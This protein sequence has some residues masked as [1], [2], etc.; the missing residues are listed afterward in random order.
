LSEYLSVSKAVLSV[1]LQLSRRACIAI[2]GIK[3]F[4][5]NPLDVEMRKRLNATCGVLIL[6][7]GILLLPIN[8]PAKSDRFKDFSFDDCDPFR[9]RARIV[10]INAKAALLVAAGQTIYVVD[11]SIGDQQLTTELTDVDGDPLD[12]GALRQGQWVLVK[13]FKHIDGGV[14]ASLVQRIDPPDHPKPIVR[15]ISKG[16]RRHKRIKQR[17]GENH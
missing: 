7:I 12:F 3:F 8:T 4:G 14:V 6:G 11:W 9:V 5:V 10:D 13:G 16:S 17:L 2:T 15:K 1:Y